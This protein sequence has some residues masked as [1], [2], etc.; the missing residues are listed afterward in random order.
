MSLRISAY[1]DEFTIALVL[2]NLADKGADISASFRPEHSHWHYPTDTCTETPLLVAAPGDTQ[3]T[4]NLYSG[5]GYTGKLGGLG[6]FNAGIYLSQTAK[7]NTQTAIRP[8]EQSGNFDIQ[9]QPGLVW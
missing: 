3:S 7:M 9:L 4:T 8:N 1:S 5:G 2:I 6:I